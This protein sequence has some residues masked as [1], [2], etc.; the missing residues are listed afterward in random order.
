MSLSLVIIGAG[1]HAISATN[2]AIS[3][4]YSV[5]AY[6]DDNKMGTT[7]LGVPVISM[8]ICSS[9]YK[10]NNYFVAVG[11]ND[12]REKIINELKIILPHAQFPSL[13][14]HSSIIGISSKIGEGTI[15]MPK[16]HIG[17]N[18][19]VETFC[20]INT[21]ASI[22]HDCYVKAFASLAPGVL[23][24]GNVK[25][26]FRS[27]VSI[28]TVVKHN[29][30]IGDDTVIGACSYVN[31]NIESKIIAYGT[32]CKFVRNRKPGESYLS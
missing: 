18:S 5:I 8:A 16:A 4:G 20:I 1:G 22:D 7:L 26:G 30:S 29:I 19:D 11:Q 3:C 27:A 6:V 10:D 28:G 15:V 21:N 23:T 31:K 12:I 13:I 32:P 24:G 9:L 17:P 25:I 14:H 2:V